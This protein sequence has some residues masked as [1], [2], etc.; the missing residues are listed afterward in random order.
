MAALRI[1]LFLFFFLLFARA[2]LS[3]RHARSQHG[4][5]LAEKA[6]A[7]LVLLLLLLPLQNECVLLCFFICCC[8]LFECVGVSV[9]AFVLLLEAQEK[10]VLFLR[11]TET[12]DNALSLRVLLECKRDLFGFVWL[13]I[14]F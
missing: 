3:E 9:F 4:E 2:L 12:S 13:I 7:L 8:C 10:R 6:Q 5:V 14:N 11:S 1:I